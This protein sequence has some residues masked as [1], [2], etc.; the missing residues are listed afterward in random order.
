MSKV[1]ID[2]QLELNEKMLS[3]TVK[4]MFTI[5]YPTLP[6]DRQF[7]I[8]SSLLGKVLIATHDS[9]MIGIN[10]IDNALKILSGTNAMAHELQ[11][12]ETNALQR[13]QIEIVGN[14]IDLMR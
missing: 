11:A 10:G 6:A 5:L 14:I 12:N 7:S 1:D 13:T 9:R 2:N 3:D 8:I 4:T